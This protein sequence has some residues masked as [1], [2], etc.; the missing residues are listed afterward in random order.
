MRNIPPGSYRLVV[1]QVRNVLP[2]PAPT[3]GTSV[4]QPEMASQPLTIESD[5]ENLLVTTSP[6]ASIKGQIVFEQGPP[7][8]MPKEIR[9]SAQAGSL[10]DGGSLPTPQP[11]LVTPQLTF[12]L[13]GLMGEYVLR[14][15][16]F[17]SPLPSGAGA[18]QVVKSVVVNGEDVTDVPHEFK[19]SDRV[20][21][22]M[23]GKVSSVE[24]TVT[25]SKGEPAAMTGVLLFSEDKTSWR[26]NSIRLRRSSTDAQGQFRMQGLMPGRYYIV[27]LGRDQMMMPG[28]T[29]FFEELSKVATTIVLNE[30]EQRKVDLRAA[31]DDIQQ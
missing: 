10:D 26:Y 1:R 25:N 30:D 18:T 11:V 6:G 4:E 3:P 19:T 23:T 7:S 14:T 31:D 5:V 17:P 22:T 28:D 21:I 29:G 24:G 8:P 27:T 16:G 15:S 9:V 12:T 2:Q 13:Q 20:T